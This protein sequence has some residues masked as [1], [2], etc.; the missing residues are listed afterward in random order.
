[1]DVGWRVI[2]PD[3]TVLASGPVLAMEAAGEVAEALRL[4]ED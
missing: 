3:G 2:A 1:M 4:E